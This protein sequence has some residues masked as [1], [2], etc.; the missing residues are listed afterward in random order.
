MGSCLQGR[1]PFSGREQAVT[2]DARRDSRLLARIYSIVLFAISLPLLLGGG[3]LVWLGGSVYYVLAGAAVFASAVW[4]WKRQREGIWMYAALVAATVPWALWESGPDGWALMPRLVAPIVLGLPLLLPAMRRGFS[5]NSERGRKLGGN[6]MAGGLTA[7][8]IAL[9][10]LAIVARPADPF[11]PIDAMG[12][13]QGQVPPPA[14]VAAAEDDGDWLHYG[15]DEAGT[16]FSPLAQIT[17][18]NVGQ[19]KEAWRAKIGPTM[20]LETTPIKVGRT[21]YV[22]NNANDVVA[23]NAENGK[24]IWRFDARVDLD[25]VP[26]AVCRGVAYYKV[27]DAAGGCS[28]RIIT[29]TIDGRLI[30]LDAATGRLCPAFGEKGMVSL[31]EGFESRNAH[32]YAVTSAPTLIDGKVVLGGWVSD[33]MEW[34]NPAGVVRAYDAV[35]GKLA[36]AW[37]VGRPDRK[38]APP[39]GETYTH[40]TPNAWA[41]FSVDT[42]LG[43]VFVPTGNPAVDYYG[44]LRRPFDEEFGSSVVAIDAATG[45]TSWRFQ[46]THHDIWDW[47]VASQPTL[48]DIPGPGGTITPAVIQPT[49][50]GEIFVL[51]RRTGRPIKAVAERPVPQGGIVPGERLSATQPFSVGMPSFRGPDLSEKTMWGIT[52]LDHLWCRIRFKEAR[53][54]GTATPPGF[55]PTIVYPGFN[56]GIDWGSV[57]V[58]PVRQ[59]LFVNSNRVA[60]HDEIITRKEATRRGVVFAEK[61]GALNAPQINTPYV[62]I[63]R[64]F[65][66]PL[67]IPCNQPPYGMLAAVDLKSG[68]MIWKQPF[69]SARASGPLGMRSMLPITV[70]TPNNGGTLVT[71][72]GL[73]FAGATH[74]GDL[75]AFDA[76]TGRMLWRTDLKAGGQAT[77][78]TYTSPE[79]GRQFVAIAAGGHYALGSV[80]G[81]SIVAFTLAD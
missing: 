71:G 32:F 29:N 54:E 61:H 68:K 65:Q 69:G 78:M 23:L 59:I 17:P 9:C 15:R 81:D 38:T 63:I 4:I 80:M 2:Q 6:A 41:P 40:S 50:R 67:G 12:L 43:L 28:E 10:V 66:S 47:D 27:P 36:W 72:S 51:D 3:Y 26:Y 53:Y 75:R 73:L 37:D 33:G 77:P 19:L 57:S 34:G 79:S 20:G 14:A 35:S 46:T 24:Q 58:D 7:A 8:A 74:D 25:K 48:V 5:W 56:G 16:R 39:Q 21:L 42:A 49:K 70:G 64:I 1:A 44:G 31:F 60:N 45:D 55:Q 62:S 22:C 30:A 18:A 13:Y 76:A 52:P 11:D